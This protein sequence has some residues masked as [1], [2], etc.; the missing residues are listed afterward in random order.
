MNYNPWIQKLISIWQN[1]LPPY[2]PSNQIKIHRLT[3]MDFLTNQNLM[4]QKHFDLNSMSSSRFVN[5]ILAPCVFRIFEMH[6]F[7]RI[8]KGWIIFVVFKIVIKLGWISRCPEQLNR[9]SCH[10]LTES[11]SH[12]LTFTF[13]IQRAILEWPFR[14]LI[15]VT[16][17]HELT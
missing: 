16:K 13:T 9:W 10:S 4:L 3:W 8:R 11:L 7:F 15:R 5:T 2:A 6:T 1:G 12:S 14:H 17:R